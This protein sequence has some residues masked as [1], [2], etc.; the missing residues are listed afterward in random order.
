[1]PH[2]SFSSHLKIGPLNHFY[3]LRGLLEQGFSGPAYIESLCPFSSTKVISTPSSDLVGCTAGKSK[4]RLFFKF[5]TSFVGPVQRLQNC[6]RLGTHSHALW[7][8]CLSQSQSTVQCEPLAPS[9]R[10][11]SFQS[12]QLPAPQLL[13]MTTIL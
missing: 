10:L 2:I 6:T 9:I 13:L 12:L 4:A 8:S 11:L 1:M 3:F 7:C 5:I